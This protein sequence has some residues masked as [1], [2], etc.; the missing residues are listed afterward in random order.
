MRFKDLSKEIK[1]TF[2]IQDLCDICEANPSEVE[3]ILRYINDKETDTNPD[4]EIDQAMLEYFARPN[5]LSHI[6]MVGYK[7]NNQNYAPAYLLLLY[8][9]LTLYIDLAPIQHT[10]AGTYLASYMQNLISE[11]QYNLILFLISNEE[12]RLTINIVQIY[13]EIFNSTLLLTLLKFKD[14]FVT[15]R[16]K[17]VSDLLLEN[18]LN[19]LKGSIDKAFLIIRAIHQ[20]D[21]PY[22]HPI[23]T[24]LAEKI[25]GKDKKFP[26]SENELIEALYIA[27]A[28]DRLDP[29]LDIKTA[30][31]AKE[32]FKKRETLYE[33]N[34]YDY[35]VK[36][37]PFLATF[38][39]G[40]GA[41]FSKTI[42]VDAL[43]KNY[44]QILDFVE[45]LRYSGADV[46]A[47][48]H[49][50]S[51]L[52]TLEWSYSPSEKQQIIL[53]Y[54]IIAGIDIKKYSEN[55][56]NLATQDC[57]NTYSLY[58]LKAFFKTT[59]NIN[60]KNYRQLTL[61]MKT[62]IFGNA[63]LS[64]VH[65]LLAN[66]ANINVKND[67]GFTALNFCANKPAILAELTLWQKLNIDTTLQDTTPFE[68]KII[69]ILTRYIQINTPTL[70]WF[71]S[72]P[73]EVSQ[74]RT[75]LNTINEYLHDTADGD[76]TCL[77]NLDSKEKR[78]INLKEFLSNAISELKK[79]KNMPNSQKTLLALYQRLIHYLD[80]HLKLSLKLELSAVKTP[81]SETRLTSLVI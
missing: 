10:I 72:E 1:K 12:L 18:G 76:S 38:F 3:S 65:L 74:V 29:S 78:T 70:S 77:V 13:S 52:T 19:L 58:S 66:G 27:V 67:M 44:S 24:D 15:Q 46:N 20:Y 50:T 60:A 49:D 5:A 33:K 80:N 35:D 57:T 54:L 40:I 73:D 14:K 39:S 17:L 64:K 53:F 28:K 34:I 7:R 23:L 6:M 59:Q 42:V 22:T 8:C 75:V 51:A 48:K 63:D 79:N 30:L 69:S 55:V 71:Y 68:K 37:I 43:S 61:L 47:Q 4:F 2:S 26:E 21:I 16:V 11:S 62:L 81:A 45:Y 56:F 25:I 32:R 41:K 31:N 9:H 36:D